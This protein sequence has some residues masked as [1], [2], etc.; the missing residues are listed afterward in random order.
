MNERSNG[1]SLWNAIFLCDIYT[2]LLNKPFTQAF[3]AETAK[4]FSFYGFGSRQYINN[5]IQMRGVWTDARTQQ[6][7]LQVTRRPYIRRE[8][9]RLLNW[10]L[11]VMKQAEKSASF[12]LAGDHIYVLRSVSY[13]HHG[14]SILR[15]RL[16]SPPTS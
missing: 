11:S 13:A 6:L 2:G 16:I 5:H 8:T 1:E 12:P 9:E 7:S 4:M 14:K 10:S 3:Y 15:H